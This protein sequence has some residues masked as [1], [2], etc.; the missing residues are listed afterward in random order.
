L[1]GSLRLELQNKILERAKRKRIYKEGPHALPL[2]F[3]QK[4]S[5]EDDVDSIGGVFCASLEDEHNAQV[6]FNERSSTI[7]KDPIQ[8]YWARACP[9]IEVQL[10][11]CKEAIRAL[12]DC[13]SKLNLMSKELYERGQWMVDRDIKWNINSVGRKENPIWTACPEVMVKIGNIVEPINE[14]IYFSKATVSAYT[15]SAFHYG[16]AGA[17]YVVG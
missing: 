7:A 13:G 8:S 1:F 14:C 10:V 2:S 6:G 16:V 11:G 5:M 4:G 17:N 15:W 9:E 12:L 3:D